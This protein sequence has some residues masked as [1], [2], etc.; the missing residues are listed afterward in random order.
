MGAKTALLAFA[1]GDIRAALRG[2]TRAERAETEAL[3][4]QVHP[5]YDVEPAD[6]GTLFEDTYPPDDIT[7][8]MKLAGVELYCDQRLV[9]GHT[10]ELPEHLRQAGAGR[11][12]IMHAMHSAVDALAFAV[13]EDG[14]LIRSLSLS[15]DSGIQE[16]IGTPYDFE[17][18][19]WAGEH[20]VKPIPGWPNQGPYPL[21]FHPLKLGEEALRAL[22]GFVIEG[23]PEPDDV[24]TEA[25]HLHGF[26]VT[27]PSGAEQAAREALYAKALRAMGP[28]R[29]F[30]MGPDGTMREVSPGSY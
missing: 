10:S 23:R 12:I 2:A 27:D 3:V 13:W 28:P 6:D 15:P 24:D 9:L 30:R 16:N 4:R 20:P 22:F 21:P 17:L 25:V 5:G 8:A 1:D 18:P 7:Y 29:T 11:R 14:E 26:R 19:Y